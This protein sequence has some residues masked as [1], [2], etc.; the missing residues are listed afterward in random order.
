MQRP[1]KAMA[2]KAV[3]TK[4][5]RRKVAVPT[6][7]F[8]ESKFPREDAVDYYE[9]PNAEIPVGKEY[10]WIAVSVMGIGASRA[11]AFQHKAS[12]WRPV[13]F[14]RHAKRFVGRSESTRHVVIGGLQL[15]ERKIPKSRPALTEAN[16]AALKMVQDH[17]A[18]Q[19][20]AGRGRTYILSDSFVAGAH[21]DRVADDADPIRVDVTIPFWLS[22]H[23]Q[24]AAAACHLSIEE[25][26]RRRVL[27]H[28]RGEIAGLLLP[29][30]EAFD[31]REIYLNEGQ[32]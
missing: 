11:N 17:P 29:N 8:P 12:G 32:R 24:D 20:K 27:L 21:Y 28:L 26:A 23:F 13:P 14:K 4:P 25:Y 10:Q 30:G 16:L 1:K 6:E 19:A 3:A 2:R 22:A 18:S 5:K 7:E 31:L 15:F 9:I